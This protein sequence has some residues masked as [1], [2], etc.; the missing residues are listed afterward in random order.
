MIVVSARDIAG[1][2]AVA[3]VALALALRYPLYILAEDLAV[4]GFRQ[5]GLTPY[6]W[7]GKVEDFL[8]SLKP[9]LILT[10][11]SLQ[12]GLEKAILLWA[13]QRGVPSLSVLDSWTNYPARFHNL[14]TG[15]KWVYLPYRLAVFDH[16]AEAELISLGAPQERLV[17]TGNP[18]F[19]Q[20]RPQDQTPARQKSAKEKLG[21]PAQD[22]LALFISEP[23]PD[24]WYATYGEYVPTGEEI[25]T[26]LSLCVRAFLEVADPHTH[27]WIK[28]HP[29]ERPT[30]AESVL[31][32]FQYPARV[33]YIQGL[34]NAPLLA[35]ADLVLGLNSNMLFETALLGLPSYSILLDAYARSGRTSIAE[36]LSNIHKC[37]DPEQIRTLFQ[38]MSLGQTGKQ[39]AVK[40]YFPDATERILAL[41]EALLGAGLAS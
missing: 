29:L 36:R 3:P 14:E 28:L 41:A 26:A 2:Y 18:Q 6:P 1:A 27:L 10:G 11:T 32:D 8:A 40:P 9:R 39:T 35:A 37:T 12:Y 38:Q 20:F 7:D 34:D 23:E 17:V 31:T 4:D 25:R 30:L 21:L 16:K 5:R 24:T 22:Y 19:A 15:E 33:R 13:K